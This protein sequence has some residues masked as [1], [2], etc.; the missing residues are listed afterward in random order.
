MR[1]GF[2]ISISG[3]FSKVL[4][5]AK[6]R[7]CEAIQLFSRNPRGWKYSPLDEEEVK[8]F[9]RD[10]E[11]GNI[12]PIFVHMPYLPN[13]ANPSKILLKPSVDSLCEDLK[14]SAILGAEYL[15]MHVGSSLGGEVKMAIKGV[16][17]GINKALAIVKNSVV[18]LLENTAG[19][20]SEIGYSF[21]QISEII[22]Q[23]NHHDRIGVALDVAHAFEA[24]YDFRTKE[25]IDNTVSEFDKLIG[26]KRLHLLHLNDSKSDF[27]S[28]VDRHWH[29]GEGKIGLDGFKLIINHPAFKNLPGIMETPR[30][31]TK[32]DL[33]NMKLIRSLVK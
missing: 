7:G 18:L 5:R 16:A 13:L 29:I 30:T 21:E 10:F 19:S 24:G 4:E 12:R 22:R 28:K 11:K 32:E 27:N 15:I 17:D 2:H 26:L 9:R 20:G 6:V 33:Q 3:G 14:R 1:F 23:I 31:N 25:T 8:I